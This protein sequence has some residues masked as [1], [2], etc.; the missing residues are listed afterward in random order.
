MVF[1]TGAME[2]SFSSMPLM[3]NPIPMN[4][5]SPNTENNNIYEKVSRPLTSVKSNAK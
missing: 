4:T 5:I 1:A 3:I 2:L